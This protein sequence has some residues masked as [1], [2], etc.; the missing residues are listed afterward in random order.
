MRTAGTEGAAIIDRKLTII[1]DYMRSAWDI[2]LDQMR[3]VLQRR[4]DNVLNGTVK[5][6]GEEFLVKN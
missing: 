1:R 5:L 6:T 3:D 2:D 4:I